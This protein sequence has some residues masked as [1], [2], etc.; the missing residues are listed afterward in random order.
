MT[1]LGK[2]IYNDELKLV[3]EESDKRRRYEIYGWKPGYEEIDGTDLYAVAQQ[4]DLGDADPLRPH[5]PRRHRQPARL[6]LRGDAGGQRSGG[7]SHGDGRDASA[8]RSCAASSRTTTSSTT[9]SDEPEIG[10]DEYDAL[11]DELRGDRGRVSPTCCT[12]DSPT[13][14]VGAAPSGPLPGGR[15]RGADALA[16][17]RP[18]RGGAARLGGRGSTTASSASTSRASEF[19]YTT[20]P[21]IDGLAIS[22]DLRGRRLHP[23]RDPWRRRRSART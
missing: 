17:Q 20:E 11:L 23:R 10:D 9:A 19:S 22:L 7:V 2:R 1:K 13:Q 14:R 21:K 16:R 8:P 18:Q 3:G 12:P 5:R 6:G 4:A 15:A